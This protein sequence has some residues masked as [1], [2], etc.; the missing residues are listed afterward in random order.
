MSC[1]Q[2]ASSNGAAQTNTAPA[3]TVILNRTSTSAG[4]GLGRYS[5]YCPKPVSSQ[6]FHQCVI[7]NTKASGDCLVLGCAPQVIQPK[8]RA[9][10]PNGIFSASILQPRRL[11]TN[12]SQ[13]SIT[14]GK[15]RTDCLPLLARRKL[16]MLA[17]YHHLA[18]E[19]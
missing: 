15:S 5:T 14:S 9:R 16:A 17:A 4:L 8:N 6:R 1:R 2:C 18:P 11:S 7:A 3:M 10:R 13:A 12:T 19:E